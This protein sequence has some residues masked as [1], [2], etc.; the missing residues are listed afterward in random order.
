MVPGTVKDTA[1]V[2]LPIL[3]MLKSIKTNH[4]LFIA[5]FESKAIIASLI[6]NFSFHDTGAHIDWKVAA[7][8]QG[9]IRGREEEGPQLPVEVRLL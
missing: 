5:L 4:G 2:S 8:V 6:G 9:Y 3:S 1:W 7:S